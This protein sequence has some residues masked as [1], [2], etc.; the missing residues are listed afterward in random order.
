MPITTL[1]PEYRKFLP[2]WQRNQ[3]AFDG[4]HA[5]KARRARYLPV[6]N[7][8]GGETVEGE[9]YQSYITRAI[10]TNYTGRT[11]QG[12]LGMATRQAPIVELPPQIEYLIGDIDNNRMSLD[13]F[14]QRVVLNV[15][16]KGRYIITADYTGRVSGDEVP[17]LEQSANERSFAKAYDATSLINWHVDRDGQLDL[18]VLKETL[19]EEIDGFAYDEIDY[20][21]EYRMIDGVAHVKEWRDEVALSDYEPIKMNGVLMDELPVMIVGAID[22][23]S[24]CDVPPISDIANVNIGHYRNSADYEEGLYICGQ[25]T[26]VINVGQMSSQDWVIANPNGVEFGSRRGIIVEQ[27]GSANLLQAQANGAAHEGMKS[28]EDQLVQ[29]G[30]QLITPKTGNETIQAAKMRAGSETSVLQIVVR[31]AQAGIEQVLKWCAGFVMANPDQV[32]FEM[33]NKF[34]DESIDPQMLVASIQLL[35]RGIFAKSDVRHLT[36][37]T[38]LLRAERTDEEIDTESE[39]SLGINFNQPIAE[40]GNQT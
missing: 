21:R 33:T 27:G 34:F 3:D 39:S 14:A 22:N 1:H 12:L 17:T 29:L 5:V 23:N 18:V 15:L 25:P 9:R 7:A 38:G 11:V 16:V 10:Y 40:V 24:T 28:K 36:R 26:P 6:P 37:S 35:D 20:Y 19:L 2:I 8:A 13:A 31:N 30:A 4:E 32:V